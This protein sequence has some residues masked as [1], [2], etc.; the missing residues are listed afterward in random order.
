[1]KTKTRL[2]CAKKEFSKLSLNFFFFRIFIMD[3]EHLLSACDHIVVN[4]F[5]N[6]SDKS[7]ADCRR[8]KK[9][10][11]HF[12]DK[13][14]F[15]YVRQLAK[16]KE[17]HRG[18]FNANQQWNN[19]IDDLQNGSESKLSDLK[20]MN[21][22][23][24][25]FFKLK[26]PSRY[27]PLEWMVSRNQIT[28]VK[29][30]LKFVQDLD[31]ETDIGSGLVF[32]PNDQGNDDLP[33]TPLMTACYH[34]YADIVKVI[35]S[36]VEGKTIDLNK[37][38]NGGQ[39]AFIHACDRGETEVVKVFLEFADELNINLN[40]RDNVGFTNGLTYAVRGKFDG[41]V[42]LLLQDPRIDVHTPD[43][44]LFTPFMIACE[45]GYHDIV[46]VFIKYVKSRKINVNAIDDEGMTALMFSC[47]NGLD[48]AVNLLLQ[49]D[50]GIEFNKTDHRGRTA[51]HWACIRGQAR[52]VHM[53]LSNAQKLK[54]NPNQ[55]DNFG[56]TAL[57][58]ACKEKE[59]YT[60][61]VFFHKAKTNQIDFNVQD[62][63]YGRTAYIWG[64]I[65]GRRGDAIFEEFNMHAQKLKID[66][67]IKDKNGRTGADYMRLSVQS[68]HYMK[69][70]EHRSNRLSL[71]M[72]KKTLI[73]YFSNDLNE[74]SD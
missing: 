61:S 7:L 51:M 41:V 57:M 47:G 58:Y 44:T 6:L 53:L 45:Q 56:M 10:W 68:G 66:V 50:I 17:K 67:K 26:Q 32:D 62:P 24:K 42:D 22:F 4:I 65:R 39:T 18:F 23:L 40:L 55:T 54:I 28:W 13:Q 33:T 43:Q 35:M 36:N 1:M 2:S 48:S 46:Q 25:E 64:C 37:R 11:K 27:D 9:S 63:K 12:I 52:V 30:L 14:K 19:I 34:G 69:D 16:R 71:L 60:L 15:Y 70:T 72:G 3:F 21:V 49:A 29:F 74:D 5:S 8:V 20:N 59:F 73:K 38:G 31:Q